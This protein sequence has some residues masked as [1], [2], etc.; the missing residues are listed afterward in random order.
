MK[1]QESATILQMIE[2]AQNIALNCHHHPDSDTVASATVLAKVLTEMGKNVT[3]LCPDTIP[4][5]LQFIEGAEKIITKAFEEVDFTQFDLLIMCD[6]STW[7]RVFI[8]TQF[9]PPTIPVV[10]IDNHVTNEKY[11]TV[12]LIDFETSAVS[13]MIYYILS[14]WGKT[15]TPSIANALMAGIVGDTG[16]FQYEIHQDTFAVAH[17]LKDL[18]ADMK[19]IN[20]HLFDTKPLGLIKFWGKTIDKLTVESNFAYAAFPLSEY[21]EYVHISGTRESAVGLIIRKVEN[22]DFGFILTEEAPNTCSISF[23]SRTG[24][25]VAQMAQELGGGGHKGASGVY[26]QGVP[27]SEALE[28]TLTVC[29]KHTNQ[30]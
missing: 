9:T 14:D 11:G 23:R 12:N 6:T 22:T 30:N 29:R 4:A 19:Q 8:S 17:A 21:S 28:K 3:I 13:Q 1:Y 26:M 7:K 10:V 20:L 24:T 27:F 2:G 16:S 18:G 5:D 25:D 15:I